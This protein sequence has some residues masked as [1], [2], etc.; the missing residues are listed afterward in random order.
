[1]IK[2]SAAAHGIT[3]LKVEHIPNRVVY[4]ADH[5]L[6]LEEFYQLFGEDDNV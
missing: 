6:T 2:M 4:I 3:K 1:M 5:P